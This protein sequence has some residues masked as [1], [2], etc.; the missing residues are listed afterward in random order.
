MVLAEHYGGGLDQYMA[1]GVDELLEVFEI[2]DGRPKK[3]SG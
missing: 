3:S 1:M 2:H